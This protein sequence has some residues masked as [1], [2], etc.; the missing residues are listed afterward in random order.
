MFR[1]QLLAFQILLCECYTLF[2]SYLHLLIWD[3][4]QS[5]IVSFKQHLLRILT[6]LYKLRL[7]SPLPYC[8]NLPEQFQGL[9]LD[10]SWSL[11]CQIHSWLKHFETTCLLLVAVFFS[12]MLVCV[13][14]LW[15]SVNISARQKHSVCAFT[16]ESSCVPFSL[17]SQAAPHSFGQ[18]YSTP[19]PGAKQVQLCVL[20]VSCFHITVPQAFKI[21]KTAYPLIPQF[22]S[23]AAHTFLF[24]ASFH[25]TIWKQLGRRKS[26]YTYVYTHTLCIWFFRRNKGCLAYQQQC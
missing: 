21:K 9:L 6:P 25:S 14:I 3:I 26:Y 22:S 7:Y 5:L 20:L 2:Q 8:G 19:L 24:L 13:V 4:C 23:I 11:S 17:C 10:Q 15:I 12:H 18:I 1:T 16:S